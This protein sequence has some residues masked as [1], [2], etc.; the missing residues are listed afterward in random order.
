MQRRSWTYWIVAVLVVVVGGLVVAFAGDGKARQQVEIVIDDAHQSYALEDFAEGETKTFR[1]GEHEVAVTRRGD[2]LE[3]VLDGEALETPATSLHL[4]GDTP[5]VW[6]GDR[7]EVEE[8]EG[9]EHGSFRYMFV[10]REEGEGE[11]DEDRVV[12]KI[13]EHMA[14][15]MG[16]EQRIHVVGPGHS[17]HNLMATSDSTVFRCPDDD[18]TLRV[19]NPR[20]T[21]AGFTCPVCGRSMQKLDEAQVQV[22][23]IRSEVE[24]GKDD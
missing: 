18:T 6:I 20:V 15:P 19:A 10:T 17:L 4:G 1:A 3:V 14:S 16:G 7:G 9:G 5:L 12:V 13:K 24:T 11:G 21:E 8:S 23:E 22:I 2:R